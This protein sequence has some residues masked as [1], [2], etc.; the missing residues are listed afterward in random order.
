MS[1]LSLYYE[2]YKKEFKDKFGI[3]PDR[4]I[5]EYVGWLMKPLLLD[6]FRELELLKEEI[7]NLKL[8]LQKLREQR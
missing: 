1:N 5:E 3:E 6:T 8:D 2:K 7:R 4:N